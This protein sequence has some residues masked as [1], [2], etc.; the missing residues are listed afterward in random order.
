MGLLREY[1]EDAG[2]AKLRQAVN[3]PWYIR[4]KTL[5]KDLRLPTIDE[6][7]E[8]AAANFAASLAAHPNPTLATVWSYDTKDYRRYKRPKIA[9]EKN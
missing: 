3:A 4:N 5:H 8:K 6:F 7:T 1:K 9:I 2:P